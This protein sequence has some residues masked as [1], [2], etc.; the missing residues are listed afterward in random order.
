MSQVVTKGSNQTLSRLFKSTMDVWLWA[1]LHTDSSCLLLQT[2]RRQWW[3][4]CT[5]VHNNLQKSV[6][7]C[8]Q[9]MADLLQTACQQVP[10]RRPQASGRLA[11]PCPCS[12]QSAPRPRTTLWWT[13]VYSGTGSS[14]TGKTRRLF[15]ST[16]ALHYIF[17]VI[18]NMLII[19]ICFFQ[20]HFISCF[21]QDKRK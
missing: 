11:S 19:W 1:Y 5:D 7:I 2:K 13:G 14:A 15:I 4:S 9:K 3:H 12:Y 6:I 18:Y 17:L 8:C 16:A 21:L 20:I 10:G